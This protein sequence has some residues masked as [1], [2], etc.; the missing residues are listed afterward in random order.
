MI[1]NNVPLNNSAMT[2]L[3]QIPARH[4]GIASLCIQ[5]IGLIMSAGLTI[6]LIFHLSS[7]T[8]TRNTKQ[9]PKRPAATHT[10]IFNMTT[11]CDVP[12]KSKSVLIPMSYPDNFFLKR[13]PCSHSKTFLPQRFTYF[14]N[15]TKYS[16]Y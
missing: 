7:I 11:V 3:C 13:E 2:R 5:L 12:T 16:S 4:T 9:Q 14:I 10:T 1:K 15:E 6:H 8:I